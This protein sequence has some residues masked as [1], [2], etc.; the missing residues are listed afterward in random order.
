MNDT[1]E[2]VVHVTVNLMNYVRFISD[3]FKSRRK[4]DSK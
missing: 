4:P 2:T 1:T 3:G